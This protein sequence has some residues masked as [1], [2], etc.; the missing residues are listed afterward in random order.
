MGDGTRDRGRLG[1]MNRSQRLAL[2]AALAVAV[3]SAAWT[4]V[5]FSVGRARCGT[6]VTAAA[7]PDL[8]PP[9]IRGVSR[10]SAFDMPR[11]LEPPCRAPARDRLLAGAVALAAAGVFAVGSRRLLADH[12]YVQQSKDN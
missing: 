3:T 5:P 7:A 11:S 2:T 12:A 8:K 9:P 4:V 1:A 10:R 6:A